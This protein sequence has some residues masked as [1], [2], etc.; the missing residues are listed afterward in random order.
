MTGQ[1]NII[2][3]LDRIAEW[4]KIHPEQGAELV[5]EISPIEIEKILRDFPFKI[6]SELRQLYEHGY[7]SMCSGPN[8]SRFIDIKDSSN[9]YNGFW[10]SNRIPRNEL[11]ELGRKNLTFNKDFITDEQ[12]LKNIDL[13][14]PDGCNLPIGYGD[15]KETYFVRCYQ[16]EKDYSPVLDRG[17]GLPL[18][19]YTNSL[20]DLILIWAECFEAGAYQSVFDEENNFYYLENDWNK[21]DSI[22]KKYNLT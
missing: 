5:S 3:G 9:N 12:H 11:T 8:L 14:P 19:V 13:Y 21:I 10:T 6:P 2:Q 17:I 1:Q 15:G 18:A 16:E 22:F 7:T 20:T 4:S